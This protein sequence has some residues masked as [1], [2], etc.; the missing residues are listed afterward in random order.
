MNKNLSHDKTKAGK[1]HHAHNK[2]IQIA[3]QETEARREF[4]EK[5]VMPQLQGIKIDLDNL[6]LVCLVT[7]K[8]KN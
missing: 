5:F 6:Q 1:V 4:T 7:T 2:I 8:S 3:L